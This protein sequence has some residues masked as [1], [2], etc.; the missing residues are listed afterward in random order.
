[1]AVAGRQIQRSVDAERRSEGYLA[2]AAERALA[3]RACQFLEPQRAA[4]TVLVHISTRG[5][6]ERQRAGPLR[7]QRARIEAVGPGVELPAY[8]RLQHDLAA[9]AE[10]A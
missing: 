5:Q 8:L 2:V 3:Q 7:G 1:M 6:G 10:T 9:R 4:R